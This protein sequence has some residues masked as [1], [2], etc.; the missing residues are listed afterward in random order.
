[1]M[2]K[3]GSKLIIKDNSGA[4]KVKIINL[5]VKKTYKR[6]YV[7]EGAFV[8]CVLKRFTPSLLVKKKDMVEVLIIHTKKKQNR[9]NGIF[10]MFDYNCGLLINKKKN[11]LLGSKIKTLFTKTFQ[12]NFKKYKKYTN[13]KNTM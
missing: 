3:I 8:L 11:T 9:G 7:G 12:T 1:M 2:L 5:R 4:N 13:L 10:I 6:S